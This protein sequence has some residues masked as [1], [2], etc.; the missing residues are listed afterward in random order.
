VEG[1]RRLLLLR[2]LLL[3]WLLL[4][5]QES[6][7]LTHGLHL[8]EHVG[9]SDPIGCSGLRCVCIVGLCC[10]CCG[11]IL[12]AGLALFCAAVVCALSEGRAARAL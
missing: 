11:R 6:H 7:L 4:L 12:V 5:L 2:L 8:L 3:L 10:C 9:D 1:Q